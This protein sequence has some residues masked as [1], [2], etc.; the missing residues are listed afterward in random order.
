M[1]TNLE[2]VIE[3]KK[4]MRT[5]LAKLPFVEK[6]RLLEQLNERVRGI[7]AAGSRSPLIK[8]ATKPGHK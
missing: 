3:S 6:V 1:N 5:K 2:R 8:M 7:K 4:V